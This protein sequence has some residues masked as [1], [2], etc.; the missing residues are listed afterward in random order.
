MKKSILLLGGVLFGSFSA[1][2]QSTPV[3][4]SPTNKNAVLEELTGIHC[5]YCP[6]GHRIANEISAA[7]P[8]RVVLVNVHAGGY[9]TPS[10]GE[11]DLRTTDGTAIDAFLAPSGYPAGSVQR[12]AVSGALTTGRGSWSGQVSG[13]LSQVSPVNV[14]MDATVDAT[15]RQLTLHVEIYYTA[16]FAAGTTHYLNIGM[17][18]NDFEG[19]QSN[20]GNYNASAILPNGNYLH[21]HIFR[22]FLN[23]GGTWGD[24]ID[25]SSTGVITRTV[26]MTLPASINAVDL[27][28]GKLQFFAFVGQG[29]NTAT[30]SIIYT[31][32]EITPTYTNVPNATASMQSIVNSFNVCS[33]EQIT[34]VVKVTNNGAAI[35]SLDFSTSINGG[36]PVTYNWTGSIA[37]FGSAEITLPVM[38]FTP[39]GTNNVVS[40]ITAVNGGTGALGT[41]VSQTK[42]INIGVD[43]PSTLV[44]VKVTCDR[45]GDET[46]WEIKNS[47][48]TVVASGGPYTQATANGTYPQPDVDVTL[49]NN[50]CYHAFLY[51]AYGDG[52]D[53]G[54]GNGNFQI[55]SAGVNVATVSSF[56]TSEAE[57]AMSVTEVAGVSEFANEIGLNVFP[58]PASDNLS[59]SV[60]GTNQ[61]F[62]IT[63]LDIQGRAIATTAMNNV[64]G[65]QT[66]Q[67]P[68][69]NIAAGNYIVKVASN[70]MTTVQNVVIK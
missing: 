49:A 60:K 11:P 58:N 1:M 40:T 57:K 21:Q 53:G 23:A 34:P 66:V 63:I 2:A 33:G 9:A 15:S 51:D 17:L 4:T 8:G 48:G 61:D 30:N 29:H 69:A 13:I 59:V 7:N 64:S 18:Q 35:S 12:T 10:A 20:Y 26:T 47:A 6:D 28:I 67:I 19:P 54:Y 46:T 44:T 36:T 22:G 31:G 52:F 14:A 50:E 3:S 25:A 45:Y 32:A 70:G 55:V 39:G 38:S 56:T 68:V 65:E 42:A 62:T 43:A 41:T 16:P 27:N 24:P 5:G 37:A